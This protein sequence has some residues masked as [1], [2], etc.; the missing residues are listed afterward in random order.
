[1]FV[2]LV[3]M[4]RHIVSDTCRNSAQKEIHNKAQ[5]LYRQTE[6]GESVHAE[7]ERRRRLSQSKKTMDDASTTPPCDHD[8][9]S[10]RPVKIMQHDRLTR[11]ENL[12]ARNQCHFHK[13]GKALKEIRDSRLYKQTLYE[14]FETHTRARWDMGRAQAYRLIKFYTVISN[15]SPIGDILPANEFQVRPRSFDEQTKKCF[16]EMVK[17]SC[18]LSSRGFIF[19]TQKARTIKNYHYWLEKE[20]NRS[21]SLSALRRCVK[22]ENLKSY[23]TKLDFEE[24]VPVKNSFKSEPVFDL[25]QMDGCK[26]RYLKIRNDNGYWQKTQVIEFYTGSRHMFILDAYFSES[27][28]NSVDLFTQF[29]LS[30]QFP[31]D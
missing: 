7:D 9:N 27:S 31:V 19:I 14:T 11:L 1:M 12:I 21:I 25:V 4:A 16:V 18:D 8:N 6:K 3:G 24:D 30:T 29:L 23:L 26:F 10:H 5:K 22:R 28:L 20:L 17:V 15:L 2:N 13:I